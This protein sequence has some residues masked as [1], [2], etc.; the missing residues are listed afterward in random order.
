MAS[1]GEEGELAMV[2]GTGLAAQ[3]LRASGVFLT[4]HG[5]DDHQRGRRRAD[6]L[7]DARAHVSVRRQTVVAQEGS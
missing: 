7:T 2:I 1:V 6:V 5:V 3:A 4:D